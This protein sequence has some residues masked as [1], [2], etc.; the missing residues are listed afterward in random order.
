M[1]Q[2]FSDLV[3]I[4]L[5]FQ[6]LLHLADDRIQQTILLTQHVHLEVDVGE[7]SRK[8]VIVKKV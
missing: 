2:K 3:A 4:L 5:F 8:P 7:H 6:P 1:L